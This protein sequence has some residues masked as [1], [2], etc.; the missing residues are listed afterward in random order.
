[1]IDAWY[2]L[3]I[4][5]KFFTYSFYVFDFRT[6][7]DKLSSLKVLRLS[8]NMLNRKGIES[9]SFLSLSALNELDLRNNHLEQ[10][11]A[12]LPEQVEY[13]SFFLG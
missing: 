5:F 6:S 13:M 10:F 2:N 7:L 1:M 9:A 11:P 3:L 4:S 12:E 8:Q